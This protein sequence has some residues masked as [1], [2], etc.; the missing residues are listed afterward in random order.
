MTGVEVKC[1][2]CGTEFT[3]SIEKCG[4][5][6]H[7][8]K[9]GKINHV[10]LPGVGEGK[11]FG[12]FMLKRR[13]GK[14]GMGEV[15][16]AEQTALSRLAAI[17]ILPPSMAQDDDY[18][19][20]FLREAKIAGQLHHPNI[21]AAFSAG[22]I[23]ELYF[24]A[25]R[26]IDGINLIDSLTINKMIQEKEALGI[27]LQIADALGYAWDKFKIIHRDIKPENIM[28]HEAGK[29]MLLDLGI[30]KQIEND[31]PGLTQVGIIIG[32][33]DYISPEQASGDEN[34]D[35]RTDIYSLGAT[36]YHLVTGQQ[37]FGSGVS[38]VVLARVLTDDLV[39][40][41]E[42]NPDISPATSALIMK[43]MARGS[44]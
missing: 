22:M 9:C 44:G 13:L 15:W 36:I 21:V 31:E 20:R 2:A 16:L 32:T 25:S 39:P 29:P 14:G 11:E 3:V 8:I 40:P 27:A 37:P 28:M 19:E 30:A 5:H 17:K 23:N 38:H 12:D 43:M 33:P 26:Y 7:C 10:P 6:T 41:I 24:L 1:R 34:I 42:V 18:R 35:F 4:K